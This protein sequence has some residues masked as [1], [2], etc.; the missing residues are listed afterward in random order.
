MKIIGLARYKAMLEVENSMAWY[1][2][3]AERIGMQER[4]SMIISSATVASEAYHDWSEIHKFC[5][6]HWS[7][8][9][10]T[11]GTGSGAPVLWGL[12]VPC[13]ETERITE[14]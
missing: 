13:I 4:I 2:S 11:C 12:A 3:I 6:Q 14:V 7:R 9:C 5:F 8:G 1:P 10:G